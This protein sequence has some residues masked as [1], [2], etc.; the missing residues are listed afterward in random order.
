MG[1]KLSNL[2]Q[3]HILKTSAIT[4][5]DNGDIVWDNGK[6]P[7]TRSD[8]IS[9]I[10]ERLK[11]DLKNW[12]HEKISTLYTTLLDIEIA[13]HP[14]RLQDLVNLSELPTEPIP[15]GMEKY[16]IWALDKEGSCLVGSGQLSIKKLTEV[17]RWFVTRKP[18]YCTKPDI[19][20]CYL[21]NLANSKKDCRNNQ[22]FFP[23]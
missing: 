9:Q 1:V 22:I 10:I 7:V 11:R 2:P 8:A 3:L 15:T 18:G 17:H 13:G 21:C 6:R 4:V 14:E 12:D 19:K 5:D 23:L 16:P 20:G